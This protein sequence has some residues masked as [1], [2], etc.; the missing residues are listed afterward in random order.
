MSSLSYELMAERERPTTLARLIVWSGAIVSLLD[1]LTT[2]RGLQHGNVSEA[3]ALQVLAIDRYGLA[4]A[5]ILRVMIG[6]AI[7]VLLAWLFGRLG[8]RAR[9]LL[10]IVSSIGILGTTAFVANNLSVLYLHHVLLPS[11]FMRAV[12]GPIAQI[13]HHVTG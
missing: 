11:S 4:G 7:F 1:G 2:F 9:A 13:A 3:N 6:T 5:I 12:Y 10:F 8:G